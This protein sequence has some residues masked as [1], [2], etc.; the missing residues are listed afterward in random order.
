M[1]D[2]SANASPRRPASPKRPA[3]SRKERQRKIKLMQAQFEAKRRE[4][5]FQAPVFK[6]G[7]FFYLALMA[8]MTLLGLGVL[9]ATEQN[10]GDAR[11]TRM[12]NR[13]AQASLDAI[14]EGLG[15][16]KFHCGVYPSAQEGLEAL[17]LKASPYPGWNGPYIRKMH[18][19]P[20]KRPYVYEPTNEPPVLLSLGKDGVRG[21][22]DDVVPDPALFR[23]P[24]RD[25]TWTNDWAP[26]QYRYYYVTPAKKGK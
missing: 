14:A 22:A 5:G 11:A 2:M 4:L 10:G 24:F 3:L 18:R 13:Q 15:R 21:T 26:Y 25:T 16:F 23:K 1:R 8:F 20:W 6:R 12:T 9:R 19:D 17:T 7:P